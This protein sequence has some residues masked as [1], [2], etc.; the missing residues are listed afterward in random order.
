MYT[1]K[2]ASEAARLATLAERAEQ[3]IRDGYT[4]SRDAE[5]GVTYVCKPGH[6]LASYWITDGKCD[7]PARQREALGTCKHQIAAEI[8]RDE[9]KR[10]AAQVAQLEEAYEA[11]YY[12]HMLNC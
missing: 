6:L 2:T 4:F 1:P 11:R 9:E 3:I 7:C 12:L 10:V 5:L 8:L